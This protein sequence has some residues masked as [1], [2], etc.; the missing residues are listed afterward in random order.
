M[1]VGGLRRDGLQALSE[2]DATVRVAI[3][4]GPNKGYNF[5]THPNIDKQLYSNQ[6]LLGLKDPERPFPI[7]S[8][9][10]ILKWRMQVADFSGCGCN[11]EMD[12][13]GTCVLRRYILKFKQRWLRRRETRR[14]RCRCRSTAGL[15]RPVATP[16]STSSTSARSPRTCWMSPSP[17]RCRH[18]RQDPAST[19]SALSRGVQARASCGPNVMLIL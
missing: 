11:E 7:G 14:R 12:T 6:N 8:P 9:V 1:R 17:S 2:D 4:T 18:C 10:G 5:K 16:T 13:H 19:R 3:E 15:Q